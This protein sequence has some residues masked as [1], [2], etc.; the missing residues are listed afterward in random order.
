MA[1]PDQ[2]PAQPAP[3]QPVRRTR[4]SVGPGARRINDKENTTL[5]LLANIA[6]SRKKLRSK[7]I[8]PGG[9]D[10]LKQGTGNRRAS[11]AIPPRAPPK[12]ILKPTPSISETTAHSRKPKSRIS[13]AFGSMDGDPLSNVPEVP[14]SSK[15]ALRTEEQQQK[16]AREREERERRDARRKSLANRRVSFAAE[17]TLHTF[18]E[19]EYNQDSASSADNTRRFSEPNAM[20]NDANAS[21]TTDATAETTNAQ[22]KSQRSSSGIRPTGSRIGTDD[23]ATY[24]SSDSELIEDVEDVLSDHGSEAE[25]ETIM[26]L[27]VDEMTS[28]SVGSL[29]GSP[30]AEDISDSI[31]EALRQAARQAGTQRLDSDDDGEEVIPSFGW[32]KKPQ[33]KATVPSAPA[34]EPAST[35]ATADEPT[36]ILDMDMDM[37]TAM[38]GII[39]AQTGQ[40]P[41]ANNK[42][43]SDEHTELDLTMDVTQVVGGILERQ[44]Q[45]PVAND[46]RDYSQNEATMEFTTALGSIKGRSSMAATDI[47][48]HEHDDDLSMELTTVIGSVLSGDAQS[49]AASLQRQQAMANAQD[50]N[51]GTIDMDM[52]MTTVMGGILGQPSKMDNDD[53]DDDNDNNNDNGATVTL[54][55]DMTAAVGRILGTATDEE[56]TATRANDDVTL[57]ME[58]TTALGD[59]LPG[60]QSEPATIPTS[61]S[62]VASTS[63]SAV[64]A[65]DRLNKAEAP[66]LPPPNATEA[67]SP[68]KELQSPIREASSSPFKS[69][70]KSPTVAVIKAKMTR[71]QSRQSSE[72]QP[73]SES[74]GSQLTNSQSTQPTEP[75][76]PATPAGFKSRSKSPRKALA[77]TPTEASTE[78]VTR[79][80]AKSKSPEKFDTAPPPILERNTRV[81]ARSQSPAKPPAK[82]PAP[83]SRRSMPISVV[84]NHRQSESNDA[85]TSASAQTPVSKP[86]LDASEMAAASPGL[87]T[88]EPST[89]SLKRSMATNDDVPAAPATPINLET[90]PP[91]KDRHDNKSSPNASPSVARVSRQTVQKRESGR[92]TSGIFQTDNHGLI[93]PPEVLTPKPRR[94]SGV[95]ADRTGL[96]SPKVSKLLE[97]R[98]SLD[99]VPAFTPATA[100]R[101]VTFTSPKVIEQEVMEEEAQEN[102]RIMAQKKTDGGEATL[103]LRE[104]IQSL[105]PKKRMAAVPTTATP[106]GRKSLAKLSIFSNEPT[107]TGQFDMDELPALQPNDAEGKRIHL[108]DFLN[109][110]SIRFMELNT[111]KR[112]HTIA[113]TRTDGSALDL[114]SDL[115]LERCVVAGA[116]TVPML[117]LYQHSCRELKKYI[118][119]GRRI[120]REIETE[121]FEE[122]PPLFREYMS[123]TPE[124]KALMDNQFKNVKTHARLLSKAMWYEWRMKLQDGI[125]EGL[126]RIGEGMDEDQAVI[127]KQEKLIA[128]VLPAAVA[129]KDLLIKERDNLAVF[130]QEIAACDPGELRAARNELADVTQRIDVKRQEIKDLERQLAE[131]EA[132]I[133]EA[134]K[135]R[136]ECQAAITQAEKIREECRGWSIAEVSALQDRVVA[137]EA[138]HGWKLVGISGTV[139]SMTYRDDIRVSFDA[140]AFQR[141]QANRAISATYIGADRQLRPQ[142][143][144]PERAFFVQCIR[145]YLGV[146]PQS[147]TAPGSMLRVVAATWEKARAVSA[148]VR[149]C[150][151]LFP[152]RIVHAG[153]SSNGVDIIWS[154]LIDQLETRIELMLHL[155]ARI[156]PDAGVLIDLVP[157]ARVVYGEAFNTAKMLDFWKAK[158]GERVYERAE[159]RREED[160]VPWC[161]AL[162][163]LRA[164]L[165][166]RGKKGRR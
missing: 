118:S 49:A 77:R 27:E 26:T 66:A 102:A 106:R 43:S 85:S 147:R 109:M 93:A 47:S 32:V 68:F 125:K 9:L 150:N 99:Q 87:S 22:T 61:G 110:T 152:M 163:D 20:S 70:A 112:R 64:T 13:N 122:N 28:A 165:L 40:K 146:L 18:H 31:D 157:A 1:P 45:E 6:P 105:S 39:Q 144:T 101:I 141:G 156:S 50:D 42:I 76:H 149:V 41:D 78:R 86:A 154:L 135:Q 46:S 55:M 145:D 69:P 164:R 131:T 33:A 151:T 37:T 116:C 117:E 25:D 11:L 74:T 52:D 60:G 121:T 92:L 62:T 158:A 67:S 126:V 161:E 19:V 16:T 96:G 79:A 166:A 56:A 84:L 90:P 94:L 3:I 73:V 48:D 54:G 5:N 65:I 123:A 115:T 81:R 140:A 136:A 89:E 7:S 95:G 15:V 100:P 12:S 4:A 17:A 83:A 159:R 57:G 44:M 91:L 2:T 138:K 155:Q 98:S 58:M 75:E 21:Q 10:A 29:L 8:G 97:K 129:K 103:N 38:G 51:H 153:G 36:Q 35:Q 162:V 142:P 124:F 88:L 127:E 113:P 107:S 23:S 72:S 104:M 130:A 63:A 108:H 82:V 119:E 133:V 80:R 34:S 160:K 139:L 14:P 30:G 71:A 120:V 59:I 137:L 132:G 24:G 143:E 114:A 128:S 111:T 53:D 134:T 148:D